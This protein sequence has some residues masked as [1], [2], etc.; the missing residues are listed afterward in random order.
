MG[1]C[2]GTTIHFSRKLNNSKEDNIWLLHECIHVLQFKQRGVI[3]IVESLIAQRF[4][5]YSYDLNSFK[6]YG[7]KGYNTEQ[8]AEI[9]SKEN[10]KFKDIKL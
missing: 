1:V 9:L 6:H 8:Q 5:G 10:L 4:S 2:V 7:I 3:Y